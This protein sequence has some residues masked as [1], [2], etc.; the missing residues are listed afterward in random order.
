MAKLFVFDAG[1]GGH[2][3][4]ASGHGINEKEYVLKLV[5]QA[6]EIMETEYEG[7]NVK[8]TRSNDKYLTL[9]E[10]A[11]IARNAG[12]DAFLSFHNN[13]F[14]AQSNGVESFVHSN[15]TASVPLAQKL[16][17]KIL[18]AARS[19]EKTMDRGVKKA[20]FG[21]LRGTY[22]SMLAVLTENLFLSNASDVRI[23][24]SAGMIDKLARAHVEALADEFDLKTTGKKVSGASTSVP[25]GSTKEAFK[26]KH[27]EVWME[28]GSEYKELQEKLKAVGFDPGPIDG[29][30]GQQTLEA[31]QAF[32]EAQ[33]VS[34]PLG[35]HFGVPGPATRKV[36]D[37]VVNEQKESKSG[38]PGGVL[39]KGDRGDDVRNVQRALASVYFYPD[40]DAKN[41]GVDG[42]FGPKT[43]NA[44]ERFQSIHVPDE[45]DGV[46]GPNT[47]AALEEVMDD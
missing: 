42:V 34:N 8:L 17:D 19:E 5:K 39:K 21:V 45:V 26:E 12:A 23:L 16:N 1:H 36:L 2:D 47:K 41:N 33:N 30:F 37:E 35:D 20:N 15:S 27:P 11:R 38:L 44:V 6:K 14:N 18:K 32:Q 46:Y 10:R 43:K 29:I 7:A 22:K 9:G 31:T 13:A 25:S 40:K 28:E 24:K 3:N 4:G